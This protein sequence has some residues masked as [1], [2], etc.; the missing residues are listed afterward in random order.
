M[1]LMTH[2]QGGQLRREGGVGESHHAGADA[3]GGAHGGGVADGAAHGFGAIIQ[4][5]PRHGAHNQELHLG[6]L[7]GHRNGGERHAQADEQGCC[8]GGHPFSNL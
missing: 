2:K 5:V 7:Q 3:K 8:A 1:D 6:Q 4:Q